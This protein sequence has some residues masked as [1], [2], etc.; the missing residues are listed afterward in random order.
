[1][2]SVIA[3]LMAFSLIF[4]FCECLL[5][6]FGICGIMG[7]ILLAISATLTALYVPFGGFLVV[8]ELALVAMF[9][10]FA[11]RLIFRKQKLGKLVLFETLNQEKADINDLSYLFGKSGIATTPLKPEG[12]AEFDGVSLEVAS[13][14]PFIPA[15]SKIKVVNISNRKI[16]VKEQADNSN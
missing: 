6:G 9:T 7:I 15:N 14:G 16:V 13:S 11:I 5:P 8:F 10:F 4:I 3:I 12:Y 1:M 2:I